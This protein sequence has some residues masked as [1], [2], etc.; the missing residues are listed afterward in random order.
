MTGKLVNIINQDGLSLLRGRAANSF[1]HRDAHACRF[2]LKRTKHEFALFE[3]IESRPI[4]IRQR[5]IEQRREVCGVGNEVA[6]ALEQAA[7]LRCEIRIELG[8]DAFLVLRLIR[9]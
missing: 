1:A 5:M 9:S 4:Q 8:F 6:L 3:Q 7:K 2:S